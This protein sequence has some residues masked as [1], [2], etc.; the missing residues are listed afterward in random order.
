[1]LHSLSCSAGP[2]LTRRHLALLSL[3]SR[4]Q[5]RQGQ[6]HPQDKRQGKREPSGRPACQLQAAQLHARQAPCGCR[7]THSLRCRRTCWMA[8]APAR[9]GPGQIACGGAQ[10]A[11]GIDNAQRRQPYRSHRIGSAGAIN[12]CALTRTGS[13]RPP[14]CE[15]VM[16]VRRN[17]LHL[18]LGD[19]QSQQGSWRANGTA[20]G[21]DMAHVTALKGAF[22]VGVRRAKGQARNGMQ[23]GCRQ[24]S[25]RVF[26]GG[27][28]PRAPKLKNRAGRA[29]NRPRRRL[30]P[31]AA[32]YISPHPR[33]YPRRRP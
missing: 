14:R 11:P 9:T 5:K 15:G 18:K 6:G 23:A 12:G 29:T 3:T 32:L 19:K 27:G 31:P 8:A 33:A 21:M 17:A 10:L 2:A 4:V 16:A 13:T 25:P 1:M 28:R 26:P 30:P 24:A 20:T 7:E 22:S